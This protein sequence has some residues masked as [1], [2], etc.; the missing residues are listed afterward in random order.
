MTLSEAEPMAQTLRRILEQS[1]AQKATLF[2]KDGSVLAS[3]DEDGFGAG[4][5]RTDHGSHAQHSA[6]SCT[7]GL[8]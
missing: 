3:A 5:R 2:S 7:A 1:Q 8:N 4:P 6:E